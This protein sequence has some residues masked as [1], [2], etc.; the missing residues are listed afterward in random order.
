MASHRMQKQIQ[1]YS[2]L[3]L[4]QTLKKFAKMQNKDTSPPEFSF[5]SENIVIFLLKNAILYF[6][7][8]PIKASLPK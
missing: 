6:K 8:T 4:S 1:E 3:V 7:P 2:Y 5:V